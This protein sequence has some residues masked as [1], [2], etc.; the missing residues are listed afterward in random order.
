MR[1]LAKNKY[2]LDLVEA[3]LPSHSHYSEGLDVLVIM[4]N[5]HL[6]VRKYNYN[7][8]TQVFIERSFDQL[9]LNTIN[10]E[11]IANSIRTHG[12][13]IMS[14]TVNVFVILSLY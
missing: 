9:H 12:S 3:H 14:T 1:N 4:R 11:H 10:I 6:F 13:G 8:N 5:I 7:L 2:D